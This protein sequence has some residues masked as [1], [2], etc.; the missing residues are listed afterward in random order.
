MFVSI[1][2]TLWCAA[3]LLTA[4]L[5]YAHY[6]VSG[7][8]GILVF[9]CAYCVTGVLAIPYLAA[10]PL[11]FFAGTDFQQ[12]SVS[13]WV[14]WHTV[15]PLIVG[16]YLCFDPELRIR[17]VD[18]NT[19]NSGAD[20]ALLGVALA[21]ATFGAAVWILHA[22]LPHFVLNGHFTPLFSMVAAPVLT[23]LNLIACI[24][25]LTRI[26]RL[27]ALHVW[28]AVAL[29]TTALDTGLNAFTVT[30]YGLGWY[31][32]KIE[33]LITA[34]V[35]LGVL[36]GEVKALY[37]RIAS[38]ALLDSLT[39]LRNRRSFDDAA[40]F[41]FRVS[42]RH[43]WPVAVLMLDVDHFKRFNDSFGHGA[44]DALL[45]K[46][47]TTLRKELA[48][49]SDLVA[50]YGGEEF[51][52]MLVDVDADSTCAIA[53]RL[54][55]SVRQITLTDAAGTEAT[56]TISIGIAWTKHAHALEHQALLL[57][58]DTALYEAKSRGRDRW[59]K[60]PPL[61]GEPAMAGSPAI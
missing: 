10:F 40:P 9:A 26:R 38:F 2:A 12:V 23:A 4:F 36:L 44:G 15:F 25:A 24:I 3:D 29:F 45:E 32:G 16:G 52:A 17:S 46:L 49:G 27:T 34:T 61:E 20:R 37:V 7:T 59:V 11:L 57:A 5:L 14:A 21:A 22:H 47:G 31:V 41:I 1:V 51:V 50:R 8:V 39:G 13:V 30:R 35:L 54:L 53:D 18:E 28:I 60:A 48:R 19:I 33:T 58:A 6:R 43:R 42:R 56:V 55:R